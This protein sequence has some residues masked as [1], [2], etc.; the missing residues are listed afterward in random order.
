[1]LYGGGEGGWGEGGRGLG[2][3]GE[4]GRGEGGSGGE[5][6]GAHTCACPQPTRMRLAASGSTVELLWRDVSTDR[7]TLEPVQPAVCGLPARPASC[8]PTMPNRLPTRVVPAT[9][10][11]QPPAEHCPLMTRELR[12]MPA[13]PGSGW[14]CL[15][16]QVKPTVVMYS[17]PL[18]FTKPTSRD[19]T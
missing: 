5:G 10:E 1:M 8:T 4:G 19:V 13:A 11:V 12:V 9:M 17:T 3:G 2:G 7:T 6:G 15:L 18:T 16:L 14:Y